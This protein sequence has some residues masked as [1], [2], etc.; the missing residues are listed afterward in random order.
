MINMVV[1]PVIV[2]DKN[3]FPDVPV[4]QRIRWSLFFAQF[5]PSLKRA[6]AHVDGA[7]RPAARLVQRSLCGSLLPGS[8]SQGPRFHERADQTPRL[9]AV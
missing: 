5:L 7:D 8:H 6:V 1:P 3:L 2:A 9:N 4:D